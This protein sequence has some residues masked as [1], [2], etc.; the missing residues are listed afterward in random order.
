MP[1]M[2]IWTTVRFGPAGTEATAVSAA[3]KDVNGDGKKDM[4]LYFRTKET[5]VD[6]DDNCHVSHTGQ[7]FD[8][9]AVEGSDSTTTVGCKSVR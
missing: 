5:T 3:I 9:Q 1:L 6:C 7:T 2:W 4:I 8:G